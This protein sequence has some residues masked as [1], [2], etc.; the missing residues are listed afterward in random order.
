MSFQR[1][2]IL[3][4]DF[5]SVSKMEISEPESG[6]AERQYR[7][8]GEETFINNDPCFLKG[9]VEK[10]GS[11]D[12]DGFCQSEWLEVSPTF[13]TRPREV[14]SNAVPLPG[15]EPPHMS[16]SSEFGPSSLAG[17]RIWPSAGTTNHGA[18]KVPKRRQKPKSSGPAKRRAARKS[19]RNLK[20]RLAR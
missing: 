7:K 15:H 4:V 19:P 14:P 5:L 13:C 10:F 1:N 9:S 8:L 2:P 12:I 11:R 17:N 18:R 6:E 20:G 3:T 16:R